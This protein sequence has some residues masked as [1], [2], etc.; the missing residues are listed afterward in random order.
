MDQINR[1]S[2]LS[3]MGL[4]G[5]GALLTSASRMPGVSVTQQTGNPLRTEPAISAP[6]KRVLR[7]AHLTD[8][9]VKN[10]RIAEY[11]MAAALH[12]VNSM[13][14][15]PDFIVNGGDAIMNAAALTKAT[16][17]EQ[18]NCFNRILKNEN[19]LPVY[20]CIGNHDLYGWMLPSTDHADGKL[21][22]KDEYQ[23]KRSYYS[24]TSNGWKLIVLDSIH[25]RKSVPGYYGK[26]DEEQMA[27]LRNELQETPA[28]THICIVSHIPILAI[29]CLF[30]NDIT[31]TGKLRISDNNMHY[32]SDELVKLFFGH[33]NIRA[34]LSGHIHL[35]DY[36]NY[37]GV[38]Y[39]CNG[40]VAGEWWNGKHQQFDPA[41][42]MMNFYDDGTV[43]RE[44]N[45]Y[46]WRV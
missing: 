30:D 35:V 28:D 19:S 9:H 7:V 43:T 15:K 26:L 5:T 36:V 18:W 27:W 11:G 16:V 24:F 33:T 10:E 23:L 12:A 31:S 45:Y 32:D 20:H 29:C 42:C 13:K 6:A 1:K 34:C 41:F 21:W 38:E 3:T 25:A 46:K 17:K 2:F 14:D 4:L 44:V 8:I 22:A 37:L 39:F 40:A